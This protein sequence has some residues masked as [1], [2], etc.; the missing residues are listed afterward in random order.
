[1]HTLK[2]K[3]ALWTSLYLKHAGA[4]SVYLHMENKWKNKWGS[5]WINEEGHSQCIHLSYGTLLWIQMEHMRKGHCFAPDCSVHLTYGGCVS[6]WLL[7]LTH[8]LANSSYLNQNYNWSSVSAISTAVDSTNFR[9]KTFESKNYIAADMYYVVRPVMV[10]S[11]ANVYRLFF[12]SLF[13]Q[14]YSIKI[15]IPF[16]LY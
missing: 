13:P 4:W 5:E 7:H 1:M 12:S 16:T 6:V 3:T 14:Q 11:V 9:S 15:Y 10:V 2:M 8:A